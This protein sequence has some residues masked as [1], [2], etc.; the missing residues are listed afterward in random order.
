LNG[1]LRIA[2]DAL[3]QME[4]LGYTSN[5]IAK[6]YVGQTLGDYV[7]NNPHLQ[8]AL[9]AYNKAVQGAAG[10]MTKITRGGNGSLQEVEDWKSGQQSFQPTSKLRA[11]LATMIDIMHS[12]IGSKA[13]QYNQ[14]FNSNKTARDFLSPQARADEDHVM[15]L[16]KYGPQ[17][18]GGGQ[19]AAAPQVTQPK[20]GEVRQGYSFK[21]GNPAD[22][23]S[24]EKQ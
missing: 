23:K 20:V 17:G 1:H 10:E 3:D 9:G 13:N 8:A 18:T 16:D 4:K 21:G 14:A 19:Q 22:P 6:N 5:N 11:G 12:R 2:S 24:W 15:G 7:A